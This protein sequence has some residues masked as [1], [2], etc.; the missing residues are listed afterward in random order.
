MKVAPKRVKKVDSPLLIIGLGGTGSDALLTIMD[1]FHNRF[2]L[3]KGPSGQL[4]DAPE[5]TAYLAFDTDTV[6]LQG[7]RVGNTSLRREHIFSLE[8]P[9]RLATGTVP[10]YI[11]EWFDP[12]L[13]DREI[14]NGAG[15]IRQAGRYVLFHNVDAVV[16]KLTTVI[17]NLIA[18]PSNQIMGTLEIVLTTGISGG[19]GSGTFMDM[20]YLIRHVLAVHFP[21]VKT[22]FMAYILTPPVNVDNIAGIEDNQRQMLESVGFAA[23]KE[24]DFWMNYNEHKY[25]FTQKYSESVTVTWNQ[26]PFD[27]VVLMGSAKRDGTVIQNA[28]ANCMDVLSESVLNFYAA[29]QADGSGNI[30]LRS[31][32]SNVEAQKGYIHKK[33]PANYTYMCVGA[34]VSDS[35]EEAMVTYEAKLTFDRLMALS[36]TDK[37]FTQGSKHAAPL[38]GTREGEKFLEE[39]LPLNLN[40]YEMFANEWM[41]PGFFT[42]P[43][44]T[45]KVIHD[46]SPI[47][48]CEYKNWVHDSE[49]HAKEFAVREVT[50]LHEHFQDMVKSRMVDLTYGPFETSAYLQDANNGFVG[51]IS[52]LVSMWQGDEDTCQSERNSAYADVSGI[53]YTKMADMSAVR[54]MAGAWGPAIQYKDGCLRLFHAARDYALA[55]AM[56]TELQAMQQAIVAFCNKVLPKFCEMLQ[57][58]GMSLNNDM[59]TIETT[60]QLNDIA[61]VQKLKAYIDEAF[62]SPERDKV[63]VQ[64]LS[65]MAEESLKIRLDDMGRPEGLEKMRQSFEQ[66]ADRFVSGATLM[67][68]GA[69]MDHML[70]VIMPNASQQD[71][72]QFL[73]NKLL[74]G[75]KAAAEPM[76]PLHVESSAANE[77]ISYAYTSVPDNSPVISLGVADYQK[78]E[79]I[80]PKYSQISDRIYWLNTLN[81]VPM[82]MY[83]DLDRLE[84]VYESA[85]L[86]AYGLHLVGSVRE[87]RHELHNDWSMLPSPV[88]HE[89]QKVQMPLTVMSRRDAIATMFE[90]GLANGSISLAQAAGNE[91]LIVTIRRNSGALETIDQ[92]EAKLQKII[93]D[94]SLAPEARLEQL[95]KLGQEGEKLTIEYPNYTQIFADAHGLDLTSPHGTQEEL[96]RASANTM[97]ARVFAAQYIL[98]AWR[99]QLAEQLIIQREMHEKLR[100]AMDSVSHEIADQNKISSFVTPFMAL[101]LS[102]VFT[103]GRQSVSFKDV[104]GM[105]ATLF[106][107]SDLTEDELTIYTDYCMPL[108]LMQILANDK[109]ERV[110]PND[111][112]YLADKGKEIQ[113]SIE[114]MPDDEYKTFSGN[115]KAFCKEFATTVDQIKYD[116]GSMPN[117]VR[118]KNITLMEGLL[119]AAKS[120][121]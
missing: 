82:Y 2:E 97:K 65:L 48:D 93:G 29:E 92:F 23:M 96:D 79:N 26:K 90:E 117:P 20:A 18:L 7:K 36:N 21:Q 62:G 110:N 27:Y 107:K 30:T 57:Q 95:R 58:I 111:R 81:C 52:R 12:R 15:G 94:A 102:N 5:R 61:P 66:A 70:Q 38:L 118:E 85:L 75:L 54:M 9:A 103:F 24:L 87:G 44:F 50:K 53:L 88:V 72:V 3:K 112:R 115:A 22:N 51:F 78:T 83:V 56:V 49:Q 73:S 114:R 109:D 77:Y 60:P 11:S 14:S 105:D 47:H 55:K 31:H 104:R 33:Y 74:P 4:L 119:H 98:Y 35:Q 108:V 17:H 41:D 76:L 39:F 42:D 43:A 13:T 84:R 91:Q 19:T 86:R 69:N 34:A 99:P 28:Y 8:I 80:T 120:Y 101:Y 46:T 10:S 68:N 6:Q 16:S 100:R 25:P 121:S 64:V 71:Q 45:P 116:R 59:H 106:N 37:V 89:L 40:Y 63:A 32:L 1:K 67:I 113:K